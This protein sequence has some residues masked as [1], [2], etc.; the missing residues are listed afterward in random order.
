MNEIE[1]AFSS[2]M[3]RAC[4]TSQSTPER[5]LDRISV[6]DYLT[7]LDIGAFNVERAAPQRVRFNVVLEVNAPQSSGKD[8]VDL[9]LSYDTITDA[10]DTEIKEQRFNLLET[11]AERI[12]ARI[13]KSP[14][15]H[16]VFVRIEKL[17]RGPGA[18]GVE[19]VRSS[20]DAI[21]LDKE[22]SASV[23]LYIVEHFNLD[24][25]IE[26]PAIFVAAP[27]KDHIAAHHNKAETAAARAWLLS[28]D[29]SAWHLSAKMPDALVC[30]SR[31]ELDWALKGGHCAIWA[32][33]KMVL[34]QTQC[35][36]LYCQGFEAILHWFLD[37][38]SIETVENQTRY[39]V[40]APEIKTA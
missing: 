28:L 15:S 12:A 23:P 38:W 25:P 4:A 35:A 8:N 16:R 40:K 17:D 5:P 34:D 24:N 31:T 20:D 11:L 22:Q 6:R 33:Q 14:L 29:Q 30:S 18:L 32:P 7:R 37:L 9:V 36:M 27:P 2:P 19:I 10:I 1:M 39:L 13:L 26:G 21:A 3:S